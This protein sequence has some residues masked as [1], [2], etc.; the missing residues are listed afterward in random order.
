MNNDNDCPIEALK[1]HD[2]SAYQSDYTICPV[3][4]M[5]MVSI[6]IGPEGHPEKG[7]VGMCLHCSGWFT[8]ADDNGSLRWATEQEVDSV[9]PQQVEISWK[10]HFEI[11]NKRN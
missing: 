6:T 7:D 9:S 4:C 5:N 1:G 8:V 2:V 11:T 3:C 10:A